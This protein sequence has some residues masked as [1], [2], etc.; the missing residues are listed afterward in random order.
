MTRK[1]FSIVLVDDDPKY[2]DLLRHQLRSFQNK[3][4]NITWISDPSTV[5]PSLKS[6][7]IIDLVLMD[8]FLPGTTGI[9]IIKKIYEE[10]VRIPII[11]LTSNRDFKIAIEAMKYGVEDYILKEEAANTLLP[12]SIINVIE[13]FELARRIEQAEKEDLISKKKIEA[14]QELVVT[15]CH[16]FNNP[17]AAIKISS[18]ILVRHALSDEQKQI[19]AKLN[20]NITLLEKQIVK[21]RDLNIKS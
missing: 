8:Y 12:R 20:S 21:L 7:K 2:A 10:K 3:S 6:D 17:L 19:L 11:L 14:I 5:L 9:E 1:E 16:E 4:F 13:R 18:D 15:M